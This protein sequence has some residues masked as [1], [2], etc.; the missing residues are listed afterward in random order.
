MTLSKYIHALHI[1]KGFMLYNAVTTKVIFISAE[2]FEKLGQEPGVVFSDSQ[3]RILSEKGFLSDENEFST[4]NLLKSNNQEK[5][6]VFALYLI[7]TEECNM[8]C[9]YCSQSLFRTREKMKKMSPEI[10]ESVLGKFYSVT[11]ERK[12]TIVL[13]GGEPTLNR[14]GI[15]AVI[16]YVR[17][18]KNDWIT[19][20][21]IFTNGILLEDSYIDL[22][23]KGNVYVILSMDGYEKINDTFRKCGKEGSFKYINASIDKFNKKGIQFGISLTIASHNVDRLD[24]IVKFFIEQYHPFSIGIN[25]LHYVPEGRKY[26][27]VDLDYA[28]K[29][30]IDAYKV[31]TKYGIY[32]EQI[33]RRVRPFVMS[34]PRLKDCPSCGGMVRVLP[35]GSF[36]PCGHFM[37]EEK[38]REDA[39]YKFEKSQI[40]KKWNS[41]IN[42]MINECKT[43]PAIALCG[44]GCPYNS[45]KNHGDIFSAKDKRT[46]V[47]A[48]FFLNWLLSKLVSEYYHNEFKEV[49]QQEKQKLLGNI[50]LDAFVPMQ[51]YSKYGEFK[52]DARYL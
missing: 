22:L 20:I 41:R 8:Q 12:R 21:V 1:D 25:P 40:M 45:L 51:E 37:E 5:P 14:G 6:D 32:I 52:I 10:I 44:G 2:Q 16:H 48:E 7:L 50:S 13:Y 46:C 23:E 29:K 3:L 9:T 11:T 30:M 31:A 49:T 39:A 33:M 27:S 18:K 34:T 24:E 15:E 17:E 19:E 26:I 43:C 36:G 35:D 28:S 47:Q 4:D 38:E 42:V